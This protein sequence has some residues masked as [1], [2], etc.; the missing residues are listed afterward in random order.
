[1][2][3]YLFAALSP[4]GAKPEGLFFVCRLT[5]A[6]NTGISRGEVVAG[7]TTRL[8]IFDATAR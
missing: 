7:L 3:H 2:R 8:R 4:F 6:A 1:V 5:N